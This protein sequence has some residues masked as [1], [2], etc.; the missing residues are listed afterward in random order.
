MRILGLDYGDKR[1]G[2]AVTDV[3]SI[4]AHSLDVIQRKDDEKDFQQ[5]AKIIK[6]YE[7]SEIVV[8]FPL[9]MNG[10]VGP[11]AQEVTKFV[12][13]LKSKFQI[14]VNTWDERLTTAEGEKLLIDA[15][16]SRKKR[17]G[18]IDKMAANFILQSY[19]SWRKSTGYNNNA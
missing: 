14:P 10:T 6:E 15:D 18:I 17:K 19:L 3:L 12:E 1:I 11:K 4:T 7:I 2:V 9:N 13:T 16:V 8:G 5:I